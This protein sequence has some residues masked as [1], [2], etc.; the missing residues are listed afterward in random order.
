[1]TDK[2]FVLAVRYAEAGLDDAAWDAVQDLL[3][4]DD[5]EVL[6]F[7]ASLRLK[8]GVAAEALALAEGALRAVPGDVAAW[9]IKGRAHHLAG[10]L[11]MAEAALREALRLGAAAQ[12]WNDLGN[13]LAD[14]NQPAAAI[15]AFREALAAD[16]GYS[17]AANNLGAVLASQGAFTA[18][19]AC[20][21][22]ALAATPGNLSARVNLGVALLEQGDVDAAITAFDA[23]LA[24][25]PSHKDAA[26]NRLY[27]RL[28]SDNDPARIAREHQVWGQE[29]PLAVA[30][31]DPDPARRLRVG[32]VS[33]DFRRH[34]VAFFLA[35]FLCAHDPK[36]LEVFCYADVARPDAVTRQLAAHVPHWRDTHALSDEALVAQIAEDGIDILVDLAGHTQG[37]RLPVFARRAAPLQVTGLGYPATTGLKAMDYRLCDAM[38]D[39]AGSETHATETLLRLTPSLHAFEPPP[40]APLPDAL[41]ALAAGAVTFGSFNKCAKI[42]PSCVLLWSQVLAAIPE[43]RLLIKSKALIEETTRARLAARFVAEGIDPARLDLTGWRPG[44]GEHLGLYGQVDIA[45]DTVPYNGTTTTCEAL[46]MGVP[47]LALAGRSHAARV[48]A[49]LL[50]AAGLQD[51]IAG[52]AADFVMIAKAKTA[53]LVALQA[54]RAGLRAQVAASPL[55]DAHAHARGLEAAYRALWQKA[56]RDSSAG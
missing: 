11:T 10:D 32:Y 39:P 40:S 2:R 41:P 51:W 27:A 8:A 16:P 23:V 25:D 44:D 9:H 31:R 38:T 15:D 47:V 30:I 28:Y 7:A 3:S 48:S 56:I 37:N 42:S 52:T 1:M 49:S 46:W 24:A 19:T 50:T 5:P 20:Y 34:S 12:T 29:E 17:A 21:E 54:L 4:G 36:A 53:D 22:Q 33:P 55:C 45:L 18:A 14:G 6:R 35:P 13:I 26:D 43:A